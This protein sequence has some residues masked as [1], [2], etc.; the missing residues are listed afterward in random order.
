MFPYAAVM[1]EDIEYLRSELENERRSLAML[2][3]SSPITREK[4]IALIERCQ[5][6][7]DA[8]RGRIG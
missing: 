7:I 1:A 4:A 8:V 2:P 6:A 5:R 3:P